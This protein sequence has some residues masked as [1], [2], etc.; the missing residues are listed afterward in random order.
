MRLG[1]LA[2]A[3]VPKVVRGVLLRVDDLLSLSR[4]E[5]LAARVA[6]DER[7]PLVADLLRH[8]EALGNGRGR[9]AEGKHDLK[10]LGVLDGL[11]TALALVCARAADVRARRDMGEKVERGRTRQ[12]GVCSVAD[13]DHSALGPGRQRVL[14]AQLPQGAAV[15]SPVEAMTGKWVSRVLIERTRDDLPQDGLGVVAKLGERREELINAA[16]SMPCL[17]A[18]LGLSVRLQCRAKAGVSL[19]A[20]GRARASEEEDAKRTTMATMLR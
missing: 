6:L 19:E 1:P 11:T 8:L 4:S 17:L 15:D 14:L 5:R 20:Q 7:R 2:R 18:V 10:C 9:G 3:I 12:H 16:R 13:E